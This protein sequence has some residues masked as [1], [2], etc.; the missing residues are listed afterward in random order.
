MSVYTGAE[1]I[2]FAAPQIATEKL[3]ALL[4]WLI[5]FAGAFVFLEPSPYEVV[6]VATIFLLALTGLSLRAG[7]AP[8]VLLLI[9]LNVGYGIAVVQVIDQSKSVVW[10]LVSAFLSTTAV[11]YAAMLSTN[12]EARLRWLLR[13]Y[14]AAAVTA[15]LVAI[16]AYFHLFGGLSDTFLLYE[17]ARATFNDPNVLGAF[18]VLP[19]LLLFQRILIGRPSAVI[20]NG[21]LMLVLLGGLFLSFS[22]AAW[23][24]FAFGAI[25]VMIFSFVTAGSGRERFRIV[26]IA[27]FGVVTIALLLAALLSL[28]KVAE[29]FKERASFEQAYD[30]GHFGRFGRYLLGAQ[31]GLERPLGIGPLQFSHFFPED[32]HNTFLNSFMSGGWLSGFA[33]LTLTLITI[34]IGMRFLLVPTPWRPTYQ[35]IYAAFLGV[36]AESAIIDIDHW[37]HYFLIL[38]VLWGLAVMSRAYRAQAHGDIAPAAL[39]PPAAPSYS[40]APIGGA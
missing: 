4:L 27:I 39:A 12:T 17:R 33:Y 22:R 10:V 6:G 11:F 25:L 38:G 31:L 21:V 32:A 13:G 19:G 1:R 26:V 16:G 30:L 24:Q 34:V 8:L 2:A 15:S 5:G 36:A 3:R 35:V 18:L 28:G 9:L 14:M 23:G 29:I 7:L 40:F 37:R 20:G